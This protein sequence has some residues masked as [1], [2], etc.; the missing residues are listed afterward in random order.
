MNKFGQFYSWFRSAWLQCCKWML[1]VVIVLA[2]IFEAGVGSAQPNNVPEHFK[3]QIVYVGYANRNFW[4][5]NIPRPPSPLFWRASTHADQGFMLMYIHRITHTRQN[6]GA[7]WG[8]DLGNWWHDKQH[9]M[10]GSAFFDFRFWPFTTPLL[11]PY[12][13]Y[14]V[15]GITLL[16][17]QHFAGSDLGTNFLF[18]DFMGAGV[19][20]G[21]HRNLELS[22]KLVHYSNGDIFTTNPGFDVPLVMMLGYAF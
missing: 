17:K 10:S 11:A 20:L 22:L 14:S 16:S 12:L 9:Q 8:V 6:F 15:A 1:G 19:R 5:P 18:Q 7:N 21:R 13:E 4:N 2:L 3:R